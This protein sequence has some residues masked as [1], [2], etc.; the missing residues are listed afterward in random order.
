V[1][2]FLLHRDQDFQIKPELQDT[3]YRAM[4]DNSQNPHAV[5]TARV[6]IER[7]REKQAKRP[8]PTLEPPTSDDLLTQDLELQTLWLAMAGDD[9][10]LYETA[11]RATL[12]SLT[13]PESVRYRQQV[14]VDCLDH[15]E[16][17]RELY[18][19]ALEGLAAERKA[20]GL[21]SSATPSM[22]IHRS[23]EALRLHVDILRRLRK[24]AEENRG[25]VRS[26]GFRRFFSMLE[27]ELSDEYLATIEQHLDEL[28]FRRGMLETAVLGKG[29][30]GREYVV[31]RER[32]RSRLERFFGT[33]RSSGLSFDVHPRD[34]SGA[35]ALEDIKSRGLIDVAVAVE[36]SANHVRA[37][38]TSL[39]IELAFYLGCLNLHERLTEKG[40]P[41][42]F[43]EPLPQ[44]ERS[45]VAESI[46]DVA[47]T[48]HLDER[49]VG[50]EV[51]AEGKTLVVITGANQG[52]KSTLLRALGLAQLMLQAGMFVGAES[53]RANVSAGLFT[54]FKREEDETMEG[55]K[56][57]EEL[58]RMSQ[59][60][61]HFVPGGLLLCN[62][63]FASTNER[64]GS[65]IARQIIRAL[66]ERRM[67]VFYVTHM[68][69][70]GH[71]LRAEQSQDALFLRAERLPDGGRTFKLREGEPLPTSFGEDSYL[72]IFS[73]RIEA[74]QKHAVGRQR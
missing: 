62:E 47:L 66:L 42:C 28:G 73:D 23:V 55:G 59:L 2:V 45:L 39:K 20:G 68:Y 50:N 43:P 74:E 27:A 5:G 44:D 9:D 1:K 30:K 31:R 49:T 40:E 32:E 48:L 58:R 3:I 64:E 4:V 12:S 69:D 63:S 37:F 18:G 13:D 60:A 10:F 17:A 14:L 57:D 46:Y 33:R 34:E 70:L 35:R 8:N 11:R 41:I 22:V 25:T 51:D 29:L 61:Q 71:S 26:E 38:F 54:H 6:A 67:K 7:E 36:K 53:F 52:G 65:E 16:I 19:L 21:W 15:P 56:L 72:R 24:L